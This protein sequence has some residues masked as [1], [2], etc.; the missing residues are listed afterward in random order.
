[1]LILGIETSCDETAAAVLQD[2]KILSS[3]VFSQDKI[4]AQFGGIVPEVAARKHIEII[5]PAIKEVLDNAKLSL[6]RIDLIAVTSGPGLITSLM[7][8]VDTAKTLTFVLKKHLVAINHLEGHIYANWLP[9][10]EFPILDFQFPILCLIVSGGHTELVLMRDH[11]KYKVVGSTR[12]DAAGEAFDKV[13]KLLNIG[14]PGGPA[15]SKLADFGNS[16]AYFF[17]RPMISEPN[18]DFSFSGLKTDILRLVQKKKNKFSDQEI[19]NICASFQAA[20]IDVL[21]SKTIKAA[22]YHKTKTIFLAGGV[23]ANKLLR[24]RLAKEIKKELPKIQFHFPDLKFCADNA[25]MVALAGFYHAQRKDFVGWDKI[26][27]DP[28]LGLS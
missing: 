8:G 6:N 11:G 17:P 4:H 13:A 21:I 16:K 27:V 7:V 22:K 18:F 14:Y 20:V 3:F 19:K 5:I 15:I 9:T 1:M 12:D 2:G 25:A 23:A 26:K 10:E 24:K 28:D